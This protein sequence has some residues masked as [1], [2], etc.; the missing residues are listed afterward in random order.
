[1][2]ISLSI[3]RTVNEVLRPAVLPDAGKPEVVRIHMNRP[4][5]A[6]LQ[7]LLIRRHFMMMIYDDKDDDDDD[8]VCRLRR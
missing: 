3:L 8:Y 4:F 2:S 1:M 6:V 7:A 5:R